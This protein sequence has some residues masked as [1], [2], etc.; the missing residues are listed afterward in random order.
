M[1]VLCMRE[2]VGLGDGVE[3]GDCVGVGVDVNVREMLVVGVLVAEKQAAV[4]QI[5]K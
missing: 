2:I 4:F 5:K 1:P 3:V